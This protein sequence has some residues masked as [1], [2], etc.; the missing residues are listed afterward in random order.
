MQKKTSGPQS[1]WFRQQ[2]T[3]T[4]EQIKAPRIMIIDAEWNNLWVF[5]RRSALEKASELW[6][7]LVQMSYDPNKMESTVKMVDY[8]KYLYKKQKEEKE[9]K[10]AK[11]SKW[12]KELKLSYM[13]GQNDLD[14]KVKKAREL[15]AEWYNVKMLIRLRWRERIYSSMAQE[16]LMTIVETLSDVSRS[17]YNTPKKEAQWFS[18]ILFAKSK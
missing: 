17:Q 18:I 15:F 2:R 11:T 14:L 6:L 8:G 12:L 9:K 1:R 5:W 16:K 7:D 3:F 4:N 13:I 10:K